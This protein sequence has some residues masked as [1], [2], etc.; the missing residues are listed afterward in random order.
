MH[1]LFD[2][3]LVLLVMPKAVFLALEIIP[4]EPEADCQ[5]DVYSL[6]AFVF[7]LCTYFQGLSPTLKF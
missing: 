1:L 7:S 2:Y 4:Q 5:W 3:F 6:V